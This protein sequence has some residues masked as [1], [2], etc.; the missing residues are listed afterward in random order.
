MNMKLQSA[1]AAPA[2]C[3]SL[4]FGLRRTR[5]TV[6]LD[7]SLGAAIRGPS[8][9]LIALS[10][11]STLI[12]CEPSAPPERSER[13]DAGNETSKVGRDA[14]TDAGVGKLGRDA[15][16]R[17]FPDAGEQ[18][19][20][21]S[22]EGA[23]TDGGRPVYDGDPRRPEFCKRSGEDRVRDLFCLGPLVP[24]D[25]LR[26]L[27]SALRFTVL[28]IE[29][30]DAEEL[31]ASIEPSTLVST[32]VF[33]GHSTALSGRLVSPLNPRAILLGEDTFATFQRGVQ[34]V[35]MASRARDKNGFNFYLL[36]FTQ[37]C[38]ER[39]GGCRPGDLYTP[40]VEANWKS[41]AV[42]DDEELKNT[43]SDCR[44]CHQRGREIPVLLMREL[45]FPWT[46][47]F[48][49]IAVDEPYQPQPR[50]TGQDLVHDYRAAKQDEP[51]AGQP[52][53]LLHHTVGLML[54]N[55]VENRQP[56]LFDAPAIDN[57]VWPYGPSGYAAT[58]ERSATWYQAYEAFK[59]GEQLAL[60]YFAQRPTDPQKQAKL[61]D[62][63]RRYLA[64]EISADELPDLGDIFPDDPQTRAEIGLQ[65][66]PNATPAQALVQ[67]CGSCHNDVL[68]QSIS[69]ARFNIDLTRM[70]R[71]ELDLA[72]TRIKLAP[73]APG[74]MPPPETRQL[75]VEGRKR[76]IAYLQQNVRAPEDD[77]LL[78][79]AA[80]L[81]MA[82][83]TNPSAPGPDPEY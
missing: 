7:S 81:G 55:A 72:I 6:P 68:D 53:F 28:P 61:T 8:L 78:V 60:P 24:I 70:S 57:E 9:A 54:Q 48:E 18:A 73:D 51:Y 80:R 10:T 26:T 64:Q 39:D 14:G 50:V 66:E 56:L 41:V 40:S 31:V 38:N 76:L 15:G 4:L 46:H 44:Q 52:A 12:A 2:R 63:Y 36:S 5:V 13:R 11:L 58:P 45:Q 21:K 25:S 35:E 30:P 1:S 75:D 20:D 65:I 17:V 62:A 69:R 71:A 43:T 49:P 59:R 29:G 67:A 19:S 37:S 42:Q 34:Q 16:E 82:G 23:T 77:E 27:L 32:G 22:A 3:F 83:S 33:L 47:F 79:R 74:A